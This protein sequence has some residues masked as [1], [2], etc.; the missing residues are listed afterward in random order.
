MAKGRKINNFNK[1]YLAEDATGQCVC[2]NRPYGLAISST[3]GRLKVS[4]AFPRFKFVKR[5][6]RYRGLILVKVALE[7]LQA[8]PGVI[9]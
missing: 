2:T 3:E 8:I 7:K 5:F 1:S 4:K 6:F 9:F